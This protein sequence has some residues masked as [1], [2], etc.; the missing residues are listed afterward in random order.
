MVETS[1]IQGLHIGV[2]DIGRWRH[3]DEVHLPERVSRPQPFLP[4]PQALDAILRRETL[5]ERLTRHLVPST[6]DPDLMQP[7]VLSATRQSL[8]ARFLEAAAATRGPSRA[9]LTAAA[10]L[11]EAEVA[12]DTEIQE[13]LA[14]LLRG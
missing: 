9:A 6:L 1:R 3:E 13:A 7:P 12:L 8:R 10:A 14:V 2:T 5:D 4:Q 11:L